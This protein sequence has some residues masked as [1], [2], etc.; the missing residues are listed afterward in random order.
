MTTEGN[1][2]LKQLSTVNVRKQASSFPANFVHSLDASHMFA[3]ASQCRK[4]WK[5]IYVYCFRIFYI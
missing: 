2:N 4:V 1:V 5:S 3:T